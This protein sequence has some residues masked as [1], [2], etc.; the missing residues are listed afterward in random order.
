MD[1]ILTLPALASTWAVTAMAPS[2]FVSAS[3]ATSIQVND[4]KM[5]NEMCI[6]G[7]PAS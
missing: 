1:V 6:A 4:L 3:E 5:M 7:L 2:G